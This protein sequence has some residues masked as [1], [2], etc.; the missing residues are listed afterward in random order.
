MTL[1]LALVL[2]ISTSFVAPKAE[3]VVGL[4]IKNRIT[5]V[6]GGIGTAGGLVVT[7]MGVV[8]YATA[9]TTGWAALG[10]AIAAAA[11]TGY[12]IIIAGIGLVILDDKETVADFEFVKLSQKEA[13]QF[14][15]ADIATYN[16]ELA[17]LNAIRKTMQVEIKADQTVEDAKKLWLNYSQYL[18][19]ETK[20]I[21]E[22][23]A[24]YF[25]NQR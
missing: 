4:I 6:I 3:A 25:M 2:F 23:Q 21:A 12:G 20:E 9:V 17:E 18:S 1:L 7:T 8:T 24:A 22:A 10:T 14:D 11:I 13:P 16:S 5:T 15:A 19:P